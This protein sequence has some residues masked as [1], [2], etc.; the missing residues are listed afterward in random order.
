MSGKV[1]LVIKVSKTV[2]CFRTNADRFN[3]HSI[4]VILRK[5]YLSR[6]QEGRSVFSRTGHRRPR[7]KAP[8]SAKRESFTKAYYSQVVRRERDTSLRD[9][10]FVSCERL[11]R[12]H[13]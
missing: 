12:V 2:V 13:L 1:G 4:G 9:R 6:D 8:L 7:G 10:V 11:G 3:V 5:N